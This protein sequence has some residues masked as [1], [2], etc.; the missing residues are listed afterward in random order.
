[1]FG[2][3]VCRAHA[4][5]LGGSAVQG[6]CNGAGEHVDLIAVGDGDE[7]VSILRAGAHQCGGVSTVA[8]HRP[9]IQTL[10]EPLQRGGLLV[11][12]SDV[13]LLIGEVFSKCSADLPRSQ[14]NNLHRPLDP[15]ND[16]GTH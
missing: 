6:E 14:D 11:Y 7:H 12:D 5:D 3:I 10:L 9:D 4:A 8:Q 2:E 16:P 13:V 1:M 15:P